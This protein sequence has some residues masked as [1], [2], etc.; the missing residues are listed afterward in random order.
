MWRSVVYKA[1]SFLPTA[2]ITHIELDTPF[3]KIGKQ[4]QANGNHHARKQV[5]E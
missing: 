3:K 5:L 2:A 4:I 1:P